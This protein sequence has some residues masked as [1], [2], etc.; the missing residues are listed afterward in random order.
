M[1]RKL[2]FSN[3][4]LLFF[5]LL[6]YFSKMTDGVFPRSLIICLPGVC[7][8]IQ[9]FW[10]LEK[11][12]SWDIWTRVG[13]VLPRA[14]ED[15]LKLAVARVFVVCENQKLAGSIPGPE[16]QDCAKSIQP[17]A[18]QHDGGFMTLNP[19]L[20]FACTVSTYHACAYDRLILMET[21]IWL[22]ICVVEAGSN[23]TALQGSAT[24]DALTLSPAVPEEVYSVNWSDHLL[25]RMCCILSLFV[26]LYGF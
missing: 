6:Y 12:L 19:C 21:F 4:Y 24:E 10:K 13:F 15:N 2:P 7:G 22:D 9:I 17:I 26:Q 1:H 11:E 14:V 16:V 18:I 5:I 20:L 3:S 8:C 25:D 23:F